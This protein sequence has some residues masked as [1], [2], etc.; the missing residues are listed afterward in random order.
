[1]RLQNIILAYFLIGAV[2]WA[3]GAIA[4][5]DVGIG[6]EFVNQSDSGVV[7][8][9][10]RAED[11]DD[12]SGAIQSVTE[13]LVGGLAAG[14]GLLSTITGDLFWPPTVMTVLGAPTP[15]AVLLGGAPTVAF[16]GV[17][18]AALIN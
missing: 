5:E 17:I 14:L 7:P 6:Q 18:I 3:G 11:V 8:D 13:S 9:E 2:M 10:Q 15:V 4:Y 12:S 1:M 16:Y